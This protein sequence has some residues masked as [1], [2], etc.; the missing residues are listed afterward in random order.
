[1]ECCLRVEKIYSPLVKQRRLK[2]PRSKA[3]LL[4]KI[5]TSII[6]SR[7][8]LAGVVEHDAAD[9]VLS[10]RGLWTAVLAQALHDLAG[11]ELTAAAARLWIESGASYPGS[12]SW[13][14]GQLELDDGAVRGR[15]LG[16]GAEEVQHRL[17]SLNHRV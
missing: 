13:I 9:R 7:T 11:K 14:C 2:S 17:G 3:V 12:F 8:P 16:A 6:T 10:E 5:H 15:V 4:A 1:M